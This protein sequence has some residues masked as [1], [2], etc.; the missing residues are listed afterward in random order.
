ML[1]IT[2]PTLISSVV[3][4]S[5]NRYI[6]TICP[7]DYT[8]LNHQFE[9]DKIDRKIFISVLDPRSAP[10]SPSSTR[11]AEP[12]ISVPGTPTS[13]PG[14]GVRKKLGSRHGWGLGLARANSG[15]SQSFSPGDHKTPPRLRFGSSQIPA[16]AS[17]EGESGEATSPK[18]ADAPLASQ[19]S[20]EEDP[21]AGEEEKIG[22]INISHPLI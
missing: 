17:W 9:I 19:D 14:S 10:V 2:F 18:T 16:S 12:D 7:D 6:L 1:F 21:C 4:S 15:V 22:N 13:R 3:K 20:I 5:M 8:V 11:K